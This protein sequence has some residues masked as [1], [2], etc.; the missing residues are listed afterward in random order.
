MSLDGAQ[1]PVYCVFD[2]VEAQ[3]CLDDQAGAV[4][5]WRERDALTLTE[6]RES[7]FEPP[8]IVFSESDAGKENG[9]GQ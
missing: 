2:Q 1:D 4:E 5:L 7:F 6:C 3:F 9:L 8:Q